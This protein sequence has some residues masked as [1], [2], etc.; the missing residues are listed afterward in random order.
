MVVVS[1]KILQLL[2]WHQATWC[3]KLLFFTYKMCGDWRCERRYLL[4]VLCTCDY[5]S[6]TCNL[7]NMKGKEE[8]NLN[9]VDCCFWI[10]VHLGPRAGSCHI[11]E[12]RLG[13]PDKTL[14]QKLQSV[15]R[16]PGYFNFFWDWHICILYISD[17]YYRK[18]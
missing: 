13:K 10:I 11:H 5:T 7:Q 18:I 14:F 8:K 16:R 6:G 3:F 17:K 12:M 9:A 2:L 4:L 15:V 1:L